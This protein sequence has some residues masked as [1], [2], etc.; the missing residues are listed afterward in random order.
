MK[1]LEIKLQNR[2]ADLNEKRMSVERNKFYLFIVFSAAVVVLLLYCGVIGSAVAAFLVPVIVTIYL[3][4]NNKL[5]LILWKMMYVSNHGFKINPEKFCSA[6]TLRFIFALP[7]RF[8]E[9][10]RVLK[11]LRV[12]AC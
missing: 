4:L 2:L 10:Q 12:R 5:Q 9:Q 6:N 3:C 7:D 1:N 8:R 11:N